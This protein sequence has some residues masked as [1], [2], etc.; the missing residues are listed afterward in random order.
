MDLDAVSMTSGTLRT[1]VVRSMD[2]DAPRAVECQ[3]LH[4]AT[5]HALGGR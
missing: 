3:V 5:D 2:L 4:A 1:P